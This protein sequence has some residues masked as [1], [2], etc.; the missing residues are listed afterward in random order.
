[1]LLHYHTIL[2]KDKHIYFIAVRYIDI[3]FQ[4]VKDVHF[5]CAKMVVRT[6]FQKCV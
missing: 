2:S 1:M 3:L 5:V 4:F 6:V